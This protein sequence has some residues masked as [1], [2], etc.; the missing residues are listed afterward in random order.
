[1][2]HPFQYVLAQAAQADGGIGGI[3]GGQQPAILGVHQKE[4]AVK[5]GEG[6]FLYIIRVGLRV[7]LVKGGNQLRV[8]GLKDGGL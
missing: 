6:G 2:L 7:G 4:E 3:P 1:M 8:S 5:E